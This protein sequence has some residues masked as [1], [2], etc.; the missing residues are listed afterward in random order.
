MRATFFNNCSVAAWV[1]GFVV[2]FIHPIQNTTAAW[3]GYVF[4]ALMGTSIAFFFYG[5]GY[6]TLGKLRE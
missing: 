1:A 2:P 5:L 3:A 4:T 6:V